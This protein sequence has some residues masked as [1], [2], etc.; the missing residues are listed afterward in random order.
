VAEPRLIRDYL[1]ALDAML[2]A[3]IVEELADGLEGT[4]RRHVVLGLEPDAAAR[5]ALAEFGAA[6]T[7]ATAFTR[8]SPARRAARTLL[9]AGPV[10]GG[11]WAALLVA[12]HAWDW[13]VP[14]IIPLGLGAA[15][16]AVIALLVAAAWC[17]RYRTVR[18]AACVALIGL[19]L[20]DVTLP[21]LLVLPGLL[22][23]WPV[24]V[25]AGLSL[26]RAAFALE[27]WR[28]VHAA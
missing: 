5:A 4:Y 15:L 19:V 3:E 18:R 13:Q 22:R 6:E 23:G 26:A 24:L 25:A 8:A 27:A 10:V 17:G 20:L 14:V 28:R 2:P 21:G 9:G 11:C 1:A 12:G 16:A 7:I